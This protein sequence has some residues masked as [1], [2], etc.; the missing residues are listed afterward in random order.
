MKGCTSLLKAVC[1]SY[2]KV[3]VQRAFQAAYVVTTSAQACVTAVFALA[4]QGKLSHTYSP[5]LPTGRKHAGS[6]RG[7]HIH[8][9]H[10][11]ANEQLT[12]SFC[13]P[14]AP[15]GSAAS[16]SSCLRCDYFG[17]G[18]RH[19][20]FCACC[21]GETFPHVLT[22]AADREKTRGKQARAAHSC[23]FHFRDDWKMTPK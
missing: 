16:F 5:E 8:V 4:V 11:F 12:R 17:S 7:Q 2:T 15:P 21:A 23:L 10:E 19:C 1:G 18:L 6:K 22:R 14:P 20:S 13:G 3:E 9:K